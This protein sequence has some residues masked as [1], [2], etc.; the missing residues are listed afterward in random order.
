[1]NTFAKGVKY[2]VAICCEELGVDR[3]G[4]TQ[5]RAL[6]DCELTHE[7]YKKLLNA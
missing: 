2:N 1:M 5:H 3:T 6:G 7:I 4:I